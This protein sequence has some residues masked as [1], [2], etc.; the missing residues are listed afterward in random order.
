MKINRKRPTLNQKAKTAA[1]KSVAQ[2]PAPREAAVQRMKQE[3]PV[4]PE[5]I[6]P[7]VEEVP[8]QVPATLSNM[9]LPAVPDNIAAV[10]NPNFEDPEENVNPSGE[11]APFIYWHTSRSSTYAP[12]AYAAR[13]NVQE[14]DP[15]IV[16]GD[17][18]EYIGEYFRI[19]VLRSFKVFHQVDWEN[20]ITLDATLDE[21]KRKRNPKFKEMVVALVLIYY[22]TNTGKSAIV[23]TISQFR[24]AMS[25]APGDHL[26]A[27]KA[28]MKSAWIQQGKNQEEIALRQ[29]IVRATQ[30]FTAARVWSELRHKTRKTADGENT[31]PFLEVIPSPAS[32]EIIKELFAFLT[33]QECK[34][35]LDE[36]SSSFDDKKA[37]YASFDSKAAEDTQK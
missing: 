11:S 22:K 35:S 2:D 10:L 6:T 17:E 4:Q 26:R 5:T 3:K 9:D 34:E 13:N 28:S 16:N 14:G 29:V 31:Y 12:L 36:I 23:P 32:P 25:K 30:N 18:L 15:F 24:T 33:D 21:S 7:A 27:L 1:E 8:A 37:W 20:G 19:T